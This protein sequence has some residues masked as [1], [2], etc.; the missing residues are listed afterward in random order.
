MRPSAVSIAIVAA[1]AV[2]GGCRPRCDAALEP[3]PL[4]APEP[5]LTPLEARFTG[6]WRL[7]V[8]QDGDT[9]DVA[10]HPY[11]SVPSDPYPIHSA[12][13]IGRHRDNWRPGIWSVIRG[14]SA[15]LA[16]FAFFPPHGGA[17]LNF[18]LAPGD[19]LTGRFYEVFRPDSTD[20][21][22]ILRRVP[23]RAT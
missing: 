16:I 10:L 5:P 17:G 3:A 12:A 15:R 18:I 4:P 20:R 13:V 7:P 21:P 1:A 14:D 9:L 2:V 8:V 23:C 22:A 6:C 19:S 11:P